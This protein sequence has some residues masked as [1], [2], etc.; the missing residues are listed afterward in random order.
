MSSYALGRSADIWEDPEDF[1][2]VRLQRHASLN[3]CM[4][5]VVL[6]S[7]ALHTFDRGAHAADLR[8]ML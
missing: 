7:R 4:L 2:P 3:V 5:W 8:P 1:R 6:D